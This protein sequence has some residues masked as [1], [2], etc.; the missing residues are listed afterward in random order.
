MYQSSI[1]NIFIVIYTF[2]LFFFFGLKSFVS[3]FRATYTSNIGSIRK[4]CDMPTGSIHHCSLHHLY[5]SRQSVYF[6][7]YET[8]VN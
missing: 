3:V 5:L 4:T 1:H 8:I 6:L 7:T 2:I